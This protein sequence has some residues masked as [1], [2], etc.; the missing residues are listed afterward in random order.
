[1]T[2]IA[3]RFENNPILSP[4]DIDVSIDGFHI[5]GVLNPGA[6]EYK[7]RTG[8]LIRVAEIPPQVD[9]SVRAPIMDENDNL[10]ILE[11]AGDDPAVWSE[12][13][14]VFS[15]N[16]KYYLTNISHLRLAWSEDGVHF[17][18]EKEPAMRAEGQYETYGIEDC[19]VVEIDGT[20]YLTYTAVSESGVA[21]AMASTSD[22]R[23]YRRHG[24]IFPPHNKDCALFPGKI[25]GWYYA[26]H[27]PSGVDLGGN[28]IWIA[29]SKDLLHWGG[30]QCIALTRTGMWDSVRV[31]AGAAPFKTQKGWLELYH[32]ANEE[33]RY[34]LGALL[35]D[36]NNPAN[37]LARS[38]TPIMEP[39]MSYEQE[40]F[41]GNV[42]F[43]NG[44]VIH[45][46]TIT[47]YYGS[48]DEFICGAEFS[49]KQILAT[50][51]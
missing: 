9:G 43:T 38:E 42:V 46:D 24:I 15:H 40:G 19:R 35:F 13:P 31:G 12:D 41:F 34:C 49:I 23:T 28:F 45:G 20:F 14:R 8:L 22:W 36:H 16:K 37:V 17:E 21:V 4:N 5:A 25:G 1:M 7:D 39:I 11:F 2:D 32:G 47:V 30:H 6:F 3:R 26:L 29:R 48:S 18:V 51:S 10:E 50:L 44:H 27:R 33:S